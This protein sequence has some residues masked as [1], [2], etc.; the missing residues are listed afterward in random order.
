MF[1]AV[2]EIPLFRV[3]YELRRKRVGKIL[4]HRER[5]NYHATYAVDRN[6]D[7]AGKVC[8]S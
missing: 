1:S 8:Q 6:H 7:A 3:G 4:S 2:L 5:L